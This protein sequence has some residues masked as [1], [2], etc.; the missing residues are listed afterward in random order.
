MVNVE[1]PMLLAFLAGLLSFGALTI[2]Y[3]GKSL[4]NQGLPFPPGPKPKPLLGN[5]TDLT[6]SNPW[7]LYMNWGKQYGMSQSPAVVDH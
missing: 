6:L 3:L 2:R 5:I 1:A 7:V 4:R